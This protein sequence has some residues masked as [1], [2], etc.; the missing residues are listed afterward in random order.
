MSL[1]EK[2][3]L[4]AIFTSLPYT[5]PLLVWAKQ[6]EVCDRTRNPEVSFSTAFST[7]SSRCCAMSFLCC[8]VRSWQRGEMWVTRHHAATFKGLN[9]PGTHLLQRRPLLT[10]ACSR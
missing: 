1:A 5:H 10:K 3:L 7:A 8:S 9:K 6:P 4:G 2:L